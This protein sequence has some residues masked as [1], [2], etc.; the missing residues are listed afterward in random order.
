LSKNEHEFID[1]P[2]WQ[3]I[4]KRAGKKSASASTALPTSANGAGKKGK[5]VVKAD[6]K[7][8]FKKKQVGVSDMTLLSVISNESINENLKKRFESGEIYVSPRI[9]YD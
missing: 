4:S 2:Q 5:A 3:A 7:E 6:W 8:S 1:Q 9:C